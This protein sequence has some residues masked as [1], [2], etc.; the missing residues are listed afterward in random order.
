MFDKVSVNGASA[1]PVYRFLRLKS[2]PIGDPVPWNFL[3]F[4]VDRSGERVLRMPA[5]RKPESMGAE[6]EA[7]L[8]N[9]YSKASD[10]F[11]NSGS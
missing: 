2:E 6:I 3:I 10:S 8:D 5:N 11:C 1:H 9:Q 7:L 4:L